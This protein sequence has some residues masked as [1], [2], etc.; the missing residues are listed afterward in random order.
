MTRSDLETPPKKPSEEEAMS[1]EK[2]DSDDK[3]HA[4]VIALRKHLAE[5]NRCTA[6]QVFTQDL[7]PSL[8]AF[9]AV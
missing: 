9:L 6:V 1:S 7:P 5:Y 8:R 4:N 3:M 2:L